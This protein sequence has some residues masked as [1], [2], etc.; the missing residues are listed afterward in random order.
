MSPRIRNLLHWYRRTAAS[1]HYK[2]KYASQFTNFCT[3]YRPIALSHERQQQIKEKKMKAERQRRPQPRT[4]TIHL[5]PFP[6]QPLPLANQWSD[7]FCFPSKNI[8][9]CFGSPSLLSLVRALLQQFLGGSKHGSHWQ[10]LV[11]C[12]SPLLSHFPN[13]WSAGVGAQAQAPTSLAG[14]FHHLATIIWILDQ[15]LSCRSPAPVCC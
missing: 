1:F 14:C 3:S 9:V 2:G 8:L 12:L 13:T 10:H 6:C 15:K 7:G 4:T 5:L 11:I